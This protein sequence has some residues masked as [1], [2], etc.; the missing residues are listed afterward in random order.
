M[1]AAQGVEAIRPLLAVVAAPSEQIIRQ[2][3]PQH[4]T[5]GAVA[6]Q[7]HLAGGGTSGQRLSL[8][9]HPIQQPP[10]A[11]TPGGEQPVEAAGG[12]QLNRLLRVLPQPAA[13]RLI[14][15]V[16]DQK[17]PQDQHRLSNHQWSMH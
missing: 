16:S 17:S 5:A 7:G 12:Y 1:R 8:S 9:S 2:K 10:P 4:H 6:D 11:K 3:Q 13:H 15:L 14:S